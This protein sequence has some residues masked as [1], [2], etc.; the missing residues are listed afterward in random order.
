[1]DGGAANNNLLW[2]QQQILPDQL[3]TLHYDVNHVGEFK[4][5]SRVRSMVGP[6]GLGEDS[7]PFIVEIF[8]NE[9]G[10][11]SYG[12]NVTGADEKL[13]DDLSLDTWYSI[14]VEFDSGEAQTARLRYKERDAESW[15]DWSETRTMW[16]LADESKTF[17]FVS[18]NV[19]LFDN[20]SFGRLYSRDTRRRQRRRKGQPQRPQYP[21]DV[22]GPVRA[23]DRLGSGRLQRR[24]H[25]QPQ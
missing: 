25:S 9:D 24:Q 11:Q 10:T 23:I 20:I 16:Q 8:F 12:W 17:R 18:N 5:S 22:L 7:F 4:Y 2:W 21:G 14:E 13:A 1:M 15:N 6:Q 19:I 3:Q